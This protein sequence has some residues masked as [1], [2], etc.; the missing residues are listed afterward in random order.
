MCPPATCDGGTARALLARFLDAFDRSDTAALAAFLTA[1][2]ADLG[3]SRPGEEGL[4][5]WY[6][7]DGP[8]P[9][10]ARTRAEALDYFAAR[11]ARREHLR[12]GEVQYAEYERDGIVGITFALTRQADDLAAHRV[13]GKAAFACAGGT[14]VQW[15]MG[16][17]NAHR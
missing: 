16:P 4:L 5:H 17:E 2:H 14:I 9:V 7:V 1:R 10:D 3:V 11:H 15:A 13:L 6:A 8:A 12:L